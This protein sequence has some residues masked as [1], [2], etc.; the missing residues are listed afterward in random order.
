MVVVAIS[1][2]A[3]ALGFGAGTLV[4]ARLNQVPQVLVFPNANSRATYASLH[5]IREAQEISRGRGVKVG[6][7]DH[8]F[9]T[10]LH[11]ELY[12]GSGNFLGESE[13]WK[14]TDVD[15]HGYWMALTLREIAPEAEIYALNAADPQDDVKRARAIAKA[16]DWAIDQKLDVLTYSH[17]PFS[18]ESR[19]IVDPAIAKAHSAGIVTTFIHYPL[20]GNLLPGPLLDPHEEERAPDVN[21]LHFDYSVLFPFEYAKYKRGEK[22][23]YRPFLSIS[24]TSPVLGGVVA[25][26]RS[27]RPGLT[28]VECREIL[29]SSSRSS[30]FGGKGISNVLDAAAAV[31]RVRQVQVER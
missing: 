20:P 26:M 7:L 28:P 10:R 2:L 25:L 29:R 12:A 8:L 11:A 16:V 13:A 14:L 1:L 3:L 24:S 31:A 5:R 19:A 17:R 6:I 18:P 22:T 21:V 30:S 4:G 9:G 15:E 23:W 27:L